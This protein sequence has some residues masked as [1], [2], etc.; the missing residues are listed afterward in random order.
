MT[1][2]AKP[3]KIIFCIPGNSF[4]KEFITNWSFL[5]M[6][7]ERRPDITFNLSFKYCCNIYAVRNM[8][9]GVLPGKVSKN[10]KPFMG[11]LDYDYL[12]WIDSDQVFNPTHFDR[13]LDRIQVSNYSIVSGT[14]RSI[15]SRDQVGLDTLVCRHRETD[16][17]TM[18]FDELAKMETDEYGLAEIYSNGFGWMMIKHG[19]FEALDYPWFRE[20]HYIDSDDYI[21]SPGEDIV[22]SEMSRDNGF[23]TYLDPTVV[24]GHE[25]SLVI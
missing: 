7:I 11:Q 16:N 6:H 10:A 13:I 9:L 12:M 18:N 22:F 3:T 24:V 21:R 19:V 1:S 20:D 23:K 2:I 8:C 15:L 14:Y 17:R 5:L 25:K 4:T